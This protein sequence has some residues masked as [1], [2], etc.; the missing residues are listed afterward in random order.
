MLTFEALDG[1][2]FRAGQYVLIR[3]PDGDVPMSLASAPHRLPYFSL[4]YR[5]I[6]GTPEAARMDDLLARNK[7]FDISGPMGDVAVRPEPTLF[8]AAGTGAAQATSF[9]EW[10]RELQIPPPTTLLWSVATPSDLYQNSYFDALA[11]SDW[12][13]YRVFVDR[14]SGENQL[15][16]AL[17]TEPATGCDIVLSGPPGF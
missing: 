8:I 4:H 10:L 12:F 5:A 7:L 1:F 11:R 9:I 16:P 14:P 2:A 6:A 15:I 3:H 13:D 17:T